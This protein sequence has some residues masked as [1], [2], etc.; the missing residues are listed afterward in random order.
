[1]E[2]TNGLF[3]RRPRPESPP[4]SRQTSFC[5]IHTHV[6]YG[7]D[8]GSRN[9][10]ISLE[11][12]RI[13]VD[14]G[15]TDLVASPHADLRYRYD[16]AKAEAQIAELSEQMNGSIRLYRGCDFHLSFDNISD[17][18]HHPRKYTLNGQE[19]L[20]VEFPDPGIAANADE[21]LQ[22]LF[23]AGM[24]PVITHPERNSIL[25][26]RL[27]ELAGW[28]DAGA[29]LQV[30]AQSFEGRFGRRAE[31]C[32]WE[33]LRRGLVHFVASDAHDTK[34]RPP[35][36]DESYRLV[37]SRSCPA[38]ADLLFRGNPLAALRGEKIKTA[39]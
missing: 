6:L 12:L 24:R 21:L 33:L 35:K 5:D 3:R 36:L 31:A 17:A 7:V 34:H 26:N 30:T 15:T 9:A 14:H 32:A 10:G 19:C 37:T 13:A 22:S 38:V 11:M 29:F 23:N 4:G 20:L 28:V 25:R 27:D 39:T 16:A 1:M 2:W 8:D 18:L